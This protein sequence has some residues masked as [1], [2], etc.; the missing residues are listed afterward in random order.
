MKCL[1][2]LLVIVSILGLSS[3]AAAGDSLAERFARADRSEADKARD[4]GRKPVEVME[5]VGVAAGM[6]V[7][8]VIAAGG[9]YTEAL[10]VAVGPK[11]RVYAH[12]NDF[13]L[14]FRDGANEK[15]I[16]ARLAGGRLPN[17][18]RINSEIA[19]TGLPDGSIDLAF[20]ALNFHDIVNGDGEEGAAGFLAAIKK[21]LKPGGILG[22]VD[23]DANPANDNEK[24]HRMSR[25]QAVELVKKAGF[26]LVAEGDM[27]RNPNDDHS[28]MVFAEGLRGHTDRFV[29]KLRK[30]TN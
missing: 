1:R 17:V 4:A 24:L 8:D 14:G 29:L 26:E 25:A 20:T 22:I 30:P 16:T 5:F 9:W 13:V 12:N 6:T 27:L 15:A 2:T 18:E 23:H 7:V 28:K 21:M 11:G 3:T 10:T 19:D